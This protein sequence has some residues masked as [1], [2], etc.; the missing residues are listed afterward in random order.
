[1]ILENMYCSACSM[2]LA[3]TGHD[4]YSREAYYTCPNCSADYIVTETGKHTLVI[5]ADLSQEII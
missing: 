1:M 2:E 3:P 4:P 5:Q